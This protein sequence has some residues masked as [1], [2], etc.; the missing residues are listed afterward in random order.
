MAESLFV[1]TSGAEDAPAIVL[2]HGVGN[3]GL[4]WRR[5]MDA[6]P[7]FQCLA[8]D[9]PGH[10]RSAGITWA[11]RRDTA[12][13]IIELIEALPARRANVVGLSLGG[14]VALEIL[15]RRP[16][17]LDHVVI[18]GCS[19]TPARLAALMKAAVA[20]TA[21]FIRRRSVGR[22]V[23][24][25]LGVRDQAAID[26]LL[27]QFS[28][29]DPRSFRRAFADAQDV[30]ITP[31]LIGAACPTLLV[32]GERE[33]ANVR[34]S[35][36]LLAELLPRAA[37]RVMPGAGHGWLGIALDIHIGMVRSWISDE[38]LPDEL[39]PETTPPAPC[40]AAL[41]SRSPDAGRA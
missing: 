27:D 16:E 29:V 35:N 4:M 39:L 30:R 13:R 28:Q 22:V 41:A 32:A 37:S 18:D 36:R 25:A 2:L 38:P 12:D 1:R 19:A 23:A 40:P 20:V 3:T 11:S 14:S 33:L 31:A 15:G 34:A 5:H 21:P 24:T 9:L 8:P 17:A 26:D 7:E 6:L 10:G